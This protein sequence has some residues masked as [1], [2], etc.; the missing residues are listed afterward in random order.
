MG[1]NEDQ[2][3]HEN[4][5]D[6][7]PAQTE[8]T[9]S[10]MI[11]ETPRPSVDLNSNVSDAH[12]NA[13]GEQ[14]NER[15]DLVAAA[16][17]KNLKDLY[18][19]ELKDRPYCTK[20]RKKPDNELLGIINELGK[21]HLNNIQTTSGCISPWDINATMYI[22][23][24]TTQTTLKNLKEVK[25]ARATQPK[26]GWIRQLE[27]RVESI[28]RQMSQLLVVIDCKKNNKYTKHQKAL[29]IKFTKKYGNCRMSTLN[30]KL[31]LLRHNLRATA[32]TLKFKQKQNARKSINYRF[33]ID[34]KSVYR[35][36]KGENVIINKSPAR[37]D[38]ETYWQKIW[39]KTTQ[40]N[41]AA[42][43]L[44]DVKANYCPGV[45][46]ASYEMSESVIKEV[47]LK[48]SN[49]KA[50]GPD[51]IVGF[52]YKYLPFHLPYL[53]QFFT[54]SFDGRAVLPCWLTNSKT[55]LI[56]K[57]SETHLPNNYRPIAC[58]NVMLKLYTGCINNFL[59]D[60]C[61]KNQIISTEQAGGKKNVWGCSELLLIN[62]M[63]Q[64][65]VVTRQ[66][67]VVCTWLDYQKA[68]DSIPHDWMVEALVLAKVPEKVVKAIQS[69]SMSWATRLVLDSGSAS[70]T[71]LIRYSKGILQGDSLSVLLFILA[72]NPLSHLLR[73]QEGYAIGP[74]NSR[75]LNITH[76]F[77]VD[78][79]KLYAPNMDKMKLLLDIVT[80]FSQD[81]KMSFGEAKCS[82]MIVKRG[83]TVKTEEKLSLN[84][85][86]LSPL[87]G[88]ESYKYLGMD[89]T[90]R[91]DGPLNKG[92][93]VG[94]YYKRV[95]KIWASELSATNKAIAHNSF[96]VPVLTPTFGILGWTIDE[97]KSIDI[98]TRKLLA[99]S[100]NFVVTGDVD[101]LYIPRQEGGRGLKEIYTGYKSRIVSLHKHL[102]LA[103]LGN[104]YLKKVLEHE[105]HGIVRISLEI[106]QESNIEQEVN[107]TPRN[108]GKL[109]TKAITSKRK[110]A[111]SNKVMHG[112]VARKLQNITGVDAKQSLSW[113]KG[114]LMTSHF[115]GF[116]NA[117]QEQEIPTKTQLKK[118]S[119]LPT[120]Y[121]TKCRLCKIKPEDVSH[122]I[123]ACDKM[124]TRY[125]LPLRH[126]VVA[127]CIWNAL[128]KLE[129]DEWTF[130]K[131]LDG[132]S[133][134]GHIGVQGSKEFW[135]NVP[136]T[137]GTKT[138]HNRPDMVV[139]DRANKQCVIVEVSCPLDANIVAKETEKINIYGPLIRN[140][141][142]LYPDYKFNFIPIIVGT[143]GY[144]TTNLTQNLI[145][146]GFASKP[147]RESLIRKLQVLTVSGTV[148]IAKTFLKF[149]L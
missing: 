41:K 107:C 29:Q 99:M 92:K 53:A 32:E 51:K 36:M 120:T 44:P 108:A 14:P 149:K 139:W 83:R 106:Q 126:D 116:A 100:G 46:G 42:K 125:Y 101:R 84:G 69:L 8:H 121:D 67:D 37:E 102:E 119:I 40:Y 118:W 31:Q 96:A 130:D 18:S 59:G 23:A 129:C 110:D 97:L 73:A 132:E 63:I 25:N 11:T 61:L 62:K 74:P 4:A 86:S 147:H 104:P 146:L 26:P 56:P 79:L 21:Q 71:K 50:P 45:T 123:A 39:S 57:C 94:E 137:T 2:E 66:R 124:A 148:K 20:V 55:R 9:A 5:A 81:I 127:K 60:H 103:S 49:N 143:T 112:Y 140:L 111:F 68:F 64:E 80:T 114:K 133:S 43:W 136:I 13:E 33:S 141:Q 3:D 17:H 128:H 75:D 138:K 91:Y 47:L 142:L 87:H 89:E 6:T 54:L 12:S 16:W 115:E 117:I 95:R 77:Y 78:D 93:V 76:L 15:R 122:V 109:V 28:R 27:Q 70:E 82:Y 98:K 24:I 22:A 113:Q 131:N 34:A 144:V 85:L 52:W 58:Q 48:T 105:K 30:H 90:I 7:I 72:L 35:S 134:D 1:R 10:A 135:W 19:L 88:E 65:E 38:V 145:E